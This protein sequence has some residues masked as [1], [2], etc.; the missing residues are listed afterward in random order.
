MPI[1]IQELNDQIQPEKTVL[2]FGAGASVPSNAPSVSTLIEA[3]SYEFGIEADG[4]TLS[5]ISALAEDKRNRTDLIDLI[6]QQFR[7]LKAKGALLNLPSHD[8]KGIYTTNYDELVEDAYKRANKALTVFSSDF[9]FRA[10]SDPT[11]TK[12]YKLHGT[13]S[14]DSVDGFVHNMILTQTDYDSTNEYRETLYARLKDDLNPGS[15]AVIIGQS[16]KDDHLRKLIED[17]IAIN[18]KVGAG[19]RIFLVLYQQDDNRAKTYELRGLKVAF[20]SLDSFIAGMD[21]K[22]PKTVPA[23]QDTGNLLD[24]FN[25]LRPFTIDIQDEMGPE[26]SNASS[27]FNGWPASYSDIATGLTF[28]RTCSSELVK[29]LESDGKQYV[30][31]LGASG[32]GKTTAARQT[33]FRLRGNGYLAWEHKADLPLQT[34]QWINVAKRLATS[35]Q[36]GVLF[37]DEA[38]GHLYELNQLVD[39]L[40]TQGLTSLK[41]VC[42]A[43]KNHWAP[44]VKTPLFYKYGQEVQ[45]SQLDHPEVDRLLAL[46]ETNREL[47]QLVESG[48][49]GFSRGERRRRLIERCDSDMFVCLKNIFASEKFDDII[50]REFA[51]L[52]EAHAE[53]YRY[54]AAMES[55][56]IRVHRQLVMRILG[57]STN[58]IH[59]VLGGLAGIVNEY[60]INRR[61]GIYGWKVRHNVIAAIIAKYKFHDV[62]QQID[63]F[64]KVI[65]NI[66]PTYDIE[67]RTIREL[68]NIETGLPSIPDKD[69]Q[70]NLL[71]RMMSI[72]PGERVPRHRLIRNLISIGEFEKADT[73]IR[74]YE[75]DFKREASVDRYKVLLLIARATETK[76]L[77]KEDRMVILEQ[78]R[79]LAAAAADRY[80]GNKYVL[81]A[82][83]EV[84]VHA[85]KLSG[86]H[87]IFDEAMDV[88]RKAENRLGDP[89]ITKMV[90]RYE[91]RL[92]AHE[93]SISDSEPEEAAVE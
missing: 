1:A 55:S 25:T 49:S 75:K 57:V 90:I 24:A 84:G 86:S 59:A 6:R 93:I 61:E 27:I 40:A 30:C 89:D 14:R 39:Q 76:G 54:V 7:G 91:R 46:V 68:C 15:Q 44:R 20:G 2:I 77:L 50:L 78:A 53:I 56:G 79:E 9:D 71:R 80:E 65:D 60:E 72:A 41:L 28:D 70:N 85:F 10:Q 35:S 29:L 18:K 23:Y 26:L 8:W 45:L 69:V 82:Y 42:V 12:L 73:E 17:V 36:K 4:L 5:E 47:R 31:L 22:A 34:A 64:T 13:I 21:A 3:I 11:A 43:A 33:M 16:L 83:C 88:L 81:G 67:V 48:F 92:S 38:H 63:L 37:V 74:I 52:D 58:A 51:G 66:L 62:E 32:V 19:G 87:K